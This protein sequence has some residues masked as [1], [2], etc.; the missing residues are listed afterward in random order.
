MNSKTRWLLAS[1][2]NTLVR[3]FVDPDRPESRAEAKLWLF[4]QARLV[5]LA[6]TREK[7]IELHPESVQLPQI[8]HFCCDIEQPLEDADDVAGD[9]VEDAGDD[10]E[11]DDDHMAKSTAR[12]V[13]RNVDAACS[14][15]TIGKKGA[16]DAQSAG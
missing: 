15:I 8:A 9:D 4:Q 7:Q 3:T 16:T 10:A 1:N 11:A 13:W 2:S 6:L 14:A 5:F 12:Q